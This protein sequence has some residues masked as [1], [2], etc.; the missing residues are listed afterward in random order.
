MCNILWAVVAKIARIAC[1]GGGNLHV[2]LEREKGREGWCHCGNKDVLRW[3]ERENGVGRGFPRVV[4]VAG[5][6]GGEGK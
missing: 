5:S 6:R 1:G 3:K 4:V 2:T